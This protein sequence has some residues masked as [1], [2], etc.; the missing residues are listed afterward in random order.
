MEKIIKTDEQWKALLGEERYHIM[1]EKG[2]EKPYCGMFATH[3][4]PGV[5]RCA[6]C[7]LPL[8]ISEDKFESSTGW[9]SFVQP[10]ER[11][12]LEYINDFSF[13]LTKTE[14]RCA[15]CES[16]LGHVFDDGPAPTGK[17]YCINSIALTF[18]PQ[19]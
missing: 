7:G 12:N 4:E 6:A 14:V 1:R 10:Y 13:G 8:F 17:R 9:P 18:S 2:T 3:K 15:R 5:Y 16:H 11:K 19:E